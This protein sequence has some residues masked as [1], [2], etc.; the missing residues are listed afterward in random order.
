MS[1]QISNN[2]NN[3]NNYLIINIVGINSSTISN[4]IAHQVSYLNIYK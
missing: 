4:T 2:K 3:K 1:R